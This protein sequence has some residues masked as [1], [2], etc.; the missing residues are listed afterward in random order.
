MI[1][2]LIKKISKLKTDINT[3]KIESVKNDY[4]L[5]SENKKTRTLKNEIKS[6]KNVIRNSYILFILGFFGLL[7]STSLSLGGGIDR[8]HSFSKYAF[9][10]AMIFIQVAIFVV[11][12]YESVIINRFNQHY[13]LVKTCQVLLLITS[14]KF[15]FDFFK[16]K[17][18]FTLFM[19]VILD[20][21]TI[22]FIT[23]SYDFRHL[24]TKDSRK[25][26][27][28]IFKMW[29]DNKLH[30]FKSEIIKTYKENNNLES[31]GIHEIDRHPDNNFKTF[32]IEEPKKIESK[33]VEDMK[34]DIEQENNIIKFKPKQN[35]DT[36]LIKEYYDCV[37]MYANGDIAPGYKRVF[38]Q[39]KPLGITQYDT[40]TIFNQLK[41][42]G[43]LRVEGRK[44]MIEKTEFN[45]TDF[46]EMEV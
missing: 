19:C 8:Y 1:T 42:K 6:D 27:N 11:S 44:T 45:P 9:V 7:A 22:K 28:N 40:L 31:S 26:N 25:I 13:I 43:Y 30:K 34:I 10:L 37:L 17:S 21:I 14:I 5:L 20:C 38:E 36:N 12:A 32:E 3:A 35:V 16:E 18:I 39:I 33:F 46:I 2:N 41:E 23:M 15:N 4:A 24:V 29:V